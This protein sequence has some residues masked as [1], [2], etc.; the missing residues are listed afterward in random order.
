MAARPGAAEP[1]VDPLAPP[2]LV[3]A[4]PRWSGF[5]VGGHVGGSD[6]SSRTR[7]G[8]IGPTDSVAVSIGAGN[9]PAAL[10]PN[11]RNA[12]AGG[13]AGFNL[14]TGP[15]VFGLEGDFSAMHTGGR[16]SVSVNP[17]GVQV[18]THAENEL[19]TLGTVR[20]RVG[21]ALGD[22]LIYGTGGYAFGRT[23]QS[24]SINP[25]PINNPT[26]VASKAQMVGGWAAGGGIE[27]A[28]NG[29]IGMPAGPRISLRLDYL[30]Y[31]LGTQNLILGDTTGLAPGEYATMR[32]KTRGDMVRAGLSIGF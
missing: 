10:N 16:Q 24:G 5:Y 11:G 13:H 15:L 17:F 22:F 20:G 25:D 6:L 28:L 3:P 21:V 32:A 29:L 14:Q 26:Y 7:L 19:L 31:D 8:G 2:L 18:T 4:G 23:N 12:V 1:L 27:Y 9:V 30:H